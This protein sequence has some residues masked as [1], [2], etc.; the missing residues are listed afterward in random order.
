MWGRAVLGLVW[1]GRMKRLEEWDWM[2]WVLVLPV[3]MLPLERGLEQEQT[4]E[5]ELEHERQEQ[6]QE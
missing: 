1:V 6:S 5:P 4:Q 2:G 3:W